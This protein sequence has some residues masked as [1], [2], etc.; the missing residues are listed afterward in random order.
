MGRNV[1]QVGLQIRVGDILTDE[2]HFA[3]LW[4]QYRM[5]EIVQEIQMKL[6]DEYGYSKT[7]LNLNY[8]MQQYDN[9]CKAGPRQYEIRGFAREAGMIEVWKYTIVRVCEALEQVDRFTTGCKISL[10]GTGKLRAPYI[11]VNDHGPMLNLSKEIEV[12]HVGKA[13][14]LAN[15]HCEKTELNIFDEPVPKSK[16]IVDDIWF[17]GK[18]ASAYKACKYI[19]QNMREASVRWTNENILSDLPHRISSDVA[20]VIKGQLD[21]A[22]FWDNL[23]RQHIRVTRHF[24]SDFNRYSELWA[25]FSKGEPDWFQHDLTVASLDLPQYLVQK[26]VLNSDRYYHRYTD[27][28]I[29]EVCKNV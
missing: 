14:R 20:M 24:D 21:G 25:K 7:M 1:N 4:L 17:V 13:A 2:M 28:Q 23:T 19:R 6:A 22:P 8:S 27:K 11:A 5:K 10:Q 15:H 26:L 18:P 9:T 29:I 16:L 3:G 12:H